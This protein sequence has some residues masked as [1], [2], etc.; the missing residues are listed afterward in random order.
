MRA[1][2][3]L[4][5]VI[6]IL[7]GIGLGSCRSPAVKVEDPKQYLQE[8]KK[9][10]ADE[11]VTMSNQDEWKAFSDEAY[12]KIKSNENRIAELKQQVNSSH[13]RM[14]GIR[15]SGLDT[16][17]MRNKELKQRI[18]N[19]QND[20]NGWESFKKNYNSNMD[21][22]VMALRNFTVNTKGR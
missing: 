13:N 5:V 21:A 8:A 20:V 22:Q 2:F 18:A 16:L 19:Y 12:A 7:A 1:V 9:D 4:S 11:V 3:F 14:Y 15:D 10:T 17:E 6:L